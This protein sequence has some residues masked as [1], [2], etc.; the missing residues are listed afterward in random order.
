MLRRKIQSIIVDYLT[1]G[2]NKILIVN[3]A[4]QI[5][6][7][8]I[9]RYEGKRLFEN[10]IEIDLWED[11]YGPRIFSGIVS[12]EDFYLRLSS[13]AGAKMGNKNNTLVFLDEIQVYPE[14]LTLLKFLKDDDRFTYIVSGSLLGIA[15]NKAPFKPGGRVDI[16]RMF[17][18]DFEEFLW[19]NG[20]GDDF[21]ASVRDSFLK[22]ESLVN[23]V[24]D[25]MLSL[26][27]R[28]LLVGGLPD[29]VNKYVETHNIV[30]VR[31][32]QDEVY[33][34]Y[35]ADASQYDKDHKLMIERIYTLVPSYLENKFKR[36]RYNEISGKEGD[37]YQN[38][39][40]EFEYLIQSGVC[41]EVRAISN[42]HFPLKESEKKNL[43]K[44][45]LNDVG[46]L[47]NIYYRY[48]ISAVVDEIPSINLGTVYEQAVCGE[49]ASH[50][51]PL[52]YYD[53]KKKGEVDFLVD[54]HDNLSILPL[55]VK[56]GKD[57]SKHVS[58][59]TFVSNSDYGIKKAYVLS[60]EREVFAKGTVVYIPVYYVM[61]LRPSNP[62]E[63][64]FF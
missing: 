41:N 58:L 39:T 8:Y 59:D 34:L 5:G 15:L 57:Y 28:Y 16:I 50:D 38:Y 21:I 32:A 35:K 60:N 37:R 61:F 45:Y 30:E 7:S 26:F 56:S 11:N 24:H 31:S 53:N 64:P 17:Q 49:L 54:D 2:S 20:V 55:E 25:R 6:K 51:Y 19:A 36:V 52:F 1:N 27:K 9:I 43:L 18:L 23:P 3:G 40:E 10:Y 48:N 47:T 13:V 44:L 33:R 62:P 14:L 22:Q 42:P 29:A 63:N 46:L 12:K 4:R